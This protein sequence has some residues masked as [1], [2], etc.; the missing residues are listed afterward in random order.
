ME[1][2][3]KKMNELQIRL[4]RTERPQY[5]N[6][7]RPRNMEVR[8]FHCNRQVTL[9]QTV[10]TLLEKREIMKII[11]IGIIINKK[12]IDQKE[13]IIEITVIKKMKD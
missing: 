13:I 12:I 9:N 6:S 10:E 8:C 3:T 2:L 11:I 4:A 1:E 7:I 5:N